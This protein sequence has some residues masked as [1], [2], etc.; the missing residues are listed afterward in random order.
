[1]ELER[2]EWEKVVEPFSAD[3]ICIDQ[4]SKCNV[5]IEN[6]FTRTDHDHLGKMITYASGLQSWS[7][8]WGASRFR[9][10]HRSAI[11]WLNLYRV[12]RPD[13]WVLFCRPSKSVIQP[14]RLTLIL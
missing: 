6:Q 3:I 14:T 2:S 8:I 12:R 7:I 9:D 4:I 5:V 13:S 10:G 11:D 1:M